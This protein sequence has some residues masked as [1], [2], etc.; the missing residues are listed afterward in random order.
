MLH[1]RAR[2]SAPVTPERLVGQECV[3]KLADGST[4]VRRLQRG[5]R[6]GRWHLHALIGPDV[7][8][9]QAVTSCRWVAGRTLAGR[10]PQRH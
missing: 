4:V 2:E 8:R 7:L 3:V 1:L 5:S 9:D 10:P 6:K